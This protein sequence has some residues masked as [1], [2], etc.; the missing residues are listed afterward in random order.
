MWTASAGSRPTAVSCDS[1]TA[2]V[3]SKIALATSATSARVGRV[4]VTIDSS[5]CVAVIA[6]F[7]FWPAMWRIFFW[8]SGTSSIG[9]SI[10]RSPPGPAAPPHP[11]SP[12]LDDLLRVRRRLRLLDLGDHRHVAPVALEPRADG[13]EV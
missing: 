7:A 12:R 6:G 10:P 13:L 8:T 2:S 3:P 9:S 11:P 5:I 1:I 4:D